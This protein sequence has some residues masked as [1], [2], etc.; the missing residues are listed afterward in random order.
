MRSSEV[1][2]FRRR[3]S[4]LPAGAQDEPS[5]IGSLVGTAPQSYGPNNFGD[6]MGDLET[7]TFVNGAFTPLE[8]VV[9][10]ANGNLQRILSAYYGSPITIVVKKCVELE[11]GTFAR[12]VDLVMR[13]QV[14]CSA[15]GKITILSDDCYSA[16]SEGR[17]GVG[18]MFRYLKVLPSFK[19][20][21]AGRGHPTPTTAP[22][23]TLDASAPL[24]LWREYELS[25]PQLRC[26][27]VETF[28][29]NF[30]DLV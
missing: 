22:A 5:R 9:L 24:P 6:I 7:H 16:V 26:Q 23:D 4:A 15:S 29:P 12:E 19:L 2:R 20:L 17:V 11:S 30:L 28:A 3:S 27:F 21:S 18:Q 13:K 1:G 8:R 25:C 10:T 14:V